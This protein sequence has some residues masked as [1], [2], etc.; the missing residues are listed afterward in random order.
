[1]CACMR[2]KQ[3]V[4]TNSNPSDHLV[5]EIWLFVFYYPLVCDQRINTSVFTSFL[6]V[7]VLVITFMRVNIYHFFSNHLVE[8]HVHL[9]FFSSNHLAELY[10]CLL[11][12]NCCVSMCLKLKSFNWLLEF[13]SSAKQFFCVWVFFVCVFW[14]VFVFQPTDQFRQQNAL[15]RSG[16]M[17]H[18][19]SSSADGLWLERCVWQQVP[20]SQ[21]TVQKIS[22]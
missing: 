21:K 15:W 19:R 8:F 12:C 4:S 2:V 9:P 22:K 20:L 13:T 5:T 10:C 16:R 7:V 17:A 6:V 14:F 3:V 1:M 18:G 11:F